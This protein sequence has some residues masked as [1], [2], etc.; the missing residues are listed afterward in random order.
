M[1][2]LHGNGQ[3][4][5][6]ND[7]P[8]FRAVYSV[9]QNVNRVKPLEW[10]NLNFQF[11]YSSKYDFDDQQRRT[12]YERLNLLLGEPGTANTSCGKLKDEFLKPIRYYSF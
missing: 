12:I 1:K 6:T 10:V 4:F 7:E 5:V 2:I 9:F 8:V 3:T 11:W